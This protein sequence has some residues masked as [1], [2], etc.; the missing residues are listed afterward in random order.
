[1]S[2]GR[3]A[4]S[5]DREGTTAVYDPPPDSASGGGE[6]PRPSRREGTGGLSPELDLGALGGSGGQDS[7]LVLAV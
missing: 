1:M 4:H 7:G 5:Q 6:E 3:R 2:A